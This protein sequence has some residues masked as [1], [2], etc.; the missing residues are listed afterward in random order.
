MESYTRVFIRRRNIYSCFSLLYRQTQ[1]LPWVTLE[2][3][4]EFL[5]LIDI[6]NFFL[7]YTWSNIDL[8]NLIHCLV[9]HSWRRKF[10][11]KKEDIILFHAPWKPQNC[12]WR[13]QKKTARLQII[14]N[15]YSHG[16][17]VAQHLETSMEDVALTFPKFC[18][19]SFRFYIF[20]IWPSQ[21]N[22]D[23]RRYRISNQGIYF[24]C[25]KTYSWMSKTGYCTWKAIVKEELV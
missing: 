19:R 1:S 11:V 3:T 9:G 4:K 2:D 5:L 7:F 16:E 18:F 25:S 24:Y 10:M 17:W 14:F 8:W 22:S 23:L 21:K 20:F 13:V 6:S 15:P 12:I